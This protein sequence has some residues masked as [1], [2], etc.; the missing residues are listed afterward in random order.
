MAGIRD[1]RKNNKEVTKEQMDEAK[2]LIT[3][4]ATAFKDDA[5][6]AKTKAAWK[7]WNRC[8]DAQLMMKAHGTTQKKK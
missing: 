2:A 3:T 6:T 5:L 4:A 8:C 7:S 1:A